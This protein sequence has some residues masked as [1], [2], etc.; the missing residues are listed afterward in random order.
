LDIFISV[1]FLHCVISS[2]VRLIAGLF[3]AVRLM[4]YRNQCCNQATGRGY[5]VLLL[6]RP[7][8]WKTEPMYYSSVNAGLISSLETRLAYVSEELHYLTVTVLNPRYKLRLTDDSVT[9]D[10]ADHRADGR[11]WHFTAMW[12]C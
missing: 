6:I 9:K 5:S 4:P 10:N 8:M 3:N 7:A 1:Q 11:S 2:S 12:L